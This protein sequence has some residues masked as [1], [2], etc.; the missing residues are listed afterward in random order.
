MQCF[1]L[2]TDAGFFQVVDMRWG[3]RDDATN[4]H[5]TTELCLR[6]IKA[7]QEISVGPNFVVSAPL[8]LTVFTLD[9]LIICMR[10]GCWCLCLVWQT[11]LS[12]KYGYCPLLPSID[13]QEFELLLSAATDVQ[14]RDLLN[15]YG[16]KTLWS[17]YWISKGLVLWP[18]GCGTGLNNSFYQFNW[19][20]CELA[21]CS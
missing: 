6:E 5:M 10:G 18:S 13:A 19:H 8:M 4:T 15:K 17:Q 1:P 3:V 7:C 9:S 16:L 20:A 12:E 14:T 2:I 11:L 21:S